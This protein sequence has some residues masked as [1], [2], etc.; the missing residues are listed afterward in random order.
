MPAWLTEQYYTEQIQPRLRELRVREIAYAIKV[1]HAY[2]ALVRVGKRRPHP[3][4]WQ[5][6]ARLSGIP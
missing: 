6:L 3:R 5:V 2:A 1:S 4:H